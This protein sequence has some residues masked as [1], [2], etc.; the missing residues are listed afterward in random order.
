[1]SQFNVQKSIESLRN[2][3][4]QLS[5]SDTSVQTK[6]LALIEDLERQIQ[7]PQSSDAAASQK[8]PALIEQFESDH[9]QLTN[10][11]GNLLSTLSSMGI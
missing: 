8:I 3:V 5:S 6:M 7:D 9:P 11:L 10:A 1:M 2:E 4:S